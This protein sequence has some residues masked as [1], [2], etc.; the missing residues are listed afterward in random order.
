[1]T[2]KSPEEMA[3]THAFISRLREDPVAFTHVFWPEVRLY[4]EERDIMYSVRDNFETVVVAGNMLGKDFTAA[5]TVL[6]FFL[7]RTPCRIVTTSVDGTQLESVLWGEITRFIQTSHIPLDAREGGPLLV[8]HLRLRK[9]VKIERGMHGRNHALKSVYHTDGL[10]YCIGRVAKKGEGMLGHHAEADLNSARQGIPHTLLVV[11]EASGVEDISY[12]R[13]LTWAKR[14]LVIGNP[15]PPSLGCT[16][17]NKAVEG[18]DIKAE[19]VGEYAPENLDLAS[20]GLTD[21][22]QLPPKVMEPIPDP[23]QEGDDPH[24]RHTTYKPTR[25]DFYQS[26]GG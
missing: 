14:V 10:S 17:F 20:L 11:D 24:P 15:Y 9:V 23:I 19:P 22:T 26:E 12:T 7:T 2:T 18:G 13:G 16:F 4:K 3:R 25:A 1:M 21:P 5:L 8:N 6:W